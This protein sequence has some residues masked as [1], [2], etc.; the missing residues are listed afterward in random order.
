MERVER[1]M[2]VKRAADRNTVHYILYT[3]YCNRGGEGRGGVADLKRC[4]A[5]TMQWMGSEG[6]LRIL[7]PG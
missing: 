1:I 7:Q 3:I 6:V 4:L 5:Q 2:M